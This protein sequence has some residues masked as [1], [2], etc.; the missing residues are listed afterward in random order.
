MAYCYI[1]YSKR[2][3]KFYIGACNENLENRVYRH[4]TH[5]YGNFHFTARANDWVIFLAI[6][7]EDYSHAIRVERKIKS[8]KSR[9][10]LQNLKKYKDLRNKLYQQ[11]KKST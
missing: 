5:Y 4:N 9:V 11:T 1:I 10:Y 7:T 3:D 6:I 8:M 2:L